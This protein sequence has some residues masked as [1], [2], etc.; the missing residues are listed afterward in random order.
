MAS[1][2]ST[3]GVACGYHVIDH[4]YARTYSVVLVVQ[5][6]GGMCWIVLVVA[7]NTRVYLPLSWCFLVPLS[8]SRLC[9]GCR[10]RC[11]HVVVAVILVDSSLLVII[12]STFENCTIKLLNAP[13]QDGTG[14]ASGTCT[15]MSASGRWGSSAVHSTTSQACA[16]QVTLAKPKHFV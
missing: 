1:S 7:V 6:F 2:R 10:C 9:C 5:G 13:V 16:K 15:A 8:L 12:N 4:G 11:C 3:G 14:P